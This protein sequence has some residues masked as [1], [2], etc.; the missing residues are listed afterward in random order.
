VIR[1]DALLRHQKGTATIEFAFASLFL[2][3]ILMVGLDFGVYAQQNLRLGNAVE[4][5]AVLAFDNRAS[6]TI[7][8]TTLGNYVAAVAGGAP[9]MTYQCNGISCS[10]TATAK[11]IAAPATSGGW[12]TFTDP[13]TTNNVSICADGALPGYYLVIRATRTYQPVIVP[14]RYLNGKTIQQQAVVRLS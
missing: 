12:P 11:C 4:Q 10:S 14:D 5:G 1:L 6:S 13:T 3:G 9:T 8:T 2:F 7:D